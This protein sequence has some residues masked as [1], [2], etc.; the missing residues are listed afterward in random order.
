M[1][2]CGIGPSMRRMPNGF[3]RVFVE[4]TML[5]ASYRQRFG[6]WP[7]QIRMHPACLRN[8]AMILDR[9]AFEQL[10][11]RLEFQTISDWPSI[12]WG[13]ASGEAGTLGFENVP[14]QVPL[15]FS[16]DEHRRQFTEEVTRWMEL[17]QETREWL[18]VEPR[19]PANH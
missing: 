2:R 13:F 11:E 16:D 7:T 17:G 3:D 4:L 19:E 10:A 15:E 1:G 14:P 9:E 12:G 8:L 5:C 18:A 6:D